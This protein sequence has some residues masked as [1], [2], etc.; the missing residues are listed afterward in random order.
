MP[1]DQV[2]AALRRSQERMPTAQSRISL[3]QAMEGVFSAV[4]QA[5]SQALQGLTLRDLILQTE[6][7]PQSGKSV[8]HS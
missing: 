6:A 8:T 2:F 5:S 3:E 7:L 4:E 1:L